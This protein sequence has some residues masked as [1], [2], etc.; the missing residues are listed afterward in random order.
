[1]RRVLT[2]FLREV[3]AA[4]VPIS[5]AESIDYLRAATVVGVERET[6]RE[7]LA[8]AVV[9]DEVDRPIYDEVFE[10]FFSTGRTEPRTK[11]R[12]ATGGGIPGKARKGEPSTGSG[13]PREERLE[14][15]PAQPATVSLRLAE[16]A[17]RAGERG[18]ELERRQKRRRLLATPF[19]ELEP[20]AAEELP[21][22]AAELARRF[23]GRLR[24]RLR[25][26][27]RGRLDFRRT[28][29]RSVAHGG[30]P[31][32]LELRRRRPGAI[33]LVALCDVS[34]SVRH[35]TNFFVG[36]LFPCRD[37]L[38]TLRVFV[39]V[40][41]A[42]EATFEDGGLVPHEPIDLHAFSD[43]GRTLVGFERRFG[44]ALGRNTVLLVLGDAR[45]N[46]R[47]PRADV[48][49]RLRSRVRA[50]WWLV[51]E[52]RTRWG[53]GDSA[54]EAYRS[55][56]DAILECASA[57]ALLAGLDRLTR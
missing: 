36:L 38:R 30:A 25:R 13:G 24:R 7:A 26:A 9:K 5:L 41:H 27:R 28:F 42:V 17:P 52:L 21:E 45:N 29:R 51:P 22:L 31:F 14:R 55:C 39:F 49:G 12:A 20:L 40:D 44:A 33:D 18:R 47:P 37:L 1:M 50:V 54:I 15:R 4:G 3:R 35:A 6:L 2:E 8:A 23:R 57:A 43:F 19:R 34:G 10:R 48:L 11:K 53:G 46:R 16:T 56:C 32:D